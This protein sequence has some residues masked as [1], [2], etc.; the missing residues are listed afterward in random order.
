MGHMHPSVAK[1]RARTQAAKQCGRITYVQLIRTG[2]SPDQI[3]SWIRGGHLTRRLPRVYALGAVL[4]SPD[5]ALWEAVLY[6]GPDACLTAASGA[7]QRGWLNFPPSIAHVATPHR[8]KSVPD[9]RVYPRRHYAREFDNHLPVAPIPETLIDLAATAELLL[10]RR[11]L[12]VL[13]FRYQLSL[14]AILAVCTRGRPGSANLKRAL[15]RHEPEIAHTNGPLELEFLLWLER[16]H[17]PIPQFNR[18]RHGVTPDAV[19]DDLKLV[20]ELDGDGNHHSTAQK[21]KDATDQAT[22]EAHGFTVLRF[23]WQDLHHHPATIRAALTAHGIVRDTS[24]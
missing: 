16:E 14:A 23:T 6:A 4:E 12:S 8:P 11:A 3:K 10:V 20:V 2:L 1:E 17:L 22:L 21:N 9:I 24:R 18:R 5:A 13:D 19:W 7:H 15:S